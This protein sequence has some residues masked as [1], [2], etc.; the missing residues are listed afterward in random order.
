MPTKTQELDTT[1]TLV[2]PSDDAEIFKQWRDDWE[3]R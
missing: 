2:T 3:T 1:F